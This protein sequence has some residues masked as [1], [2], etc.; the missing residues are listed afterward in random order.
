LK[1]KLRIFLNI[2]LEMG[3]REMR[4]EALSKIAR[5]LMIFN[6]SKVMRK[7]RF[8]HSVRETGTRKIVNFEVLRKANRL[9]FPLSG[10]KSVKVHEIQPRNGH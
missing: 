6:E 4:R 2:I 9:D 7:Q 1:R 3:L 5:P 10:K 8:H